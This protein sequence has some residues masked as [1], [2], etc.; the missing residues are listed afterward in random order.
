MSS[1][2]EAF[3]ERNPAGQLEVSSKGQMATHSA[4]RISR[5][6]SQ[7]PRLSR[8]ASDTSPK[9]ACPSI[10]QLPQFT[11]AFLRLTLCWSFVCCHPPVQLRFRAHGFCPAASFTLDQIRRRLRRRRVLCKK[12]LGKFSKTS[13]D[14]GGGASNLQVGYRNFAWP[15]TIVHR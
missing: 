12:E 2:Q 10:S 8:G 13:G 14:S 7:M 9:P 5:R 1:F 3:L 11:T 4:R 6:A 15:G